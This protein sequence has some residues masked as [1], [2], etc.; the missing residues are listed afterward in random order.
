MRQEE[1][2]NY[3]HP[4]KFIHNNIKFRIQSSE[5]ISLFKIQQA[6]ILKQMYSNTNFEFSTVSKDIMLLKYDI[7][8]DWINEI[9]QLL[10]CDEKNN[11]IEIKSKIIDLARERKRYYEELLRENFKGKELE[12]INFWIDTHEKVY[13]LLEEKINNIDDNLDKSILFSSIVNSTSST[14]KRTLYEIQ[15][16]E[17]IF[18]QDTDVNIC[19]DNICIEIFRKDP[20]IFEEK[21]KDFTKIKKFNKITIKNYSDIDSLEIICEKVLDF[22]KE[23]NI[24]Y[25]II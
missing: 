7:W 12:F 8:Y 23:N 13:N 25:Y 17:T 21:I 15:E 18:F 14:L 3:F 10:L 16:L 24:K 19:I 2:N 11:I 1:L 4:R 20:N 5:D 22:L 6:F 9:E